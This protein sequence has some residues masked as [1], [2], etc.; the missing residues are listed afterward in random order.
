MVS[1][2]YK[3]IESRIG[4]IKFDGPN[5]FIATPTERRGDKKM[6]IDWMPLAS[7]CKYCD[8]KLEHDVHWQAFSIL[9]QICDNC[10]N[11]FIDARD[12]TIGMDE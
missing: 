5:R 4:L 1:K 3:R 9:R 7:F 2:K 10:D 6:I 12:S 8:K 11:L